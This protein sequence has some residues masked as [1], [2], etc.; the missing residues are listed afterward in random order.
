[1]EAEVDSQPSEILTRRVARRRFLQGTA[2]IGAGALLAGKLGFDMSAQVAEAAVPSTN[3]P[4]YLVSTASGVQFKPILTV[5]DLP[6][7]NGYRMVGIPDGLGAYRRGNKITLVMNHELGDTAGVVRAHGSRGAFV[8]R[9]EIKRQNL[10]VLSGQDLTQSPNDVYT[11][12]A[13]GYVAGTTAWNRFCSADMPVPPALRFGFKGTRERILLNGEESG[14]EGRAW[15]NIVTGSHAGQSWQLPRLG[16]MAFENVV[17][18]PGA[19]ERTV[20]AC[21]DDGT[22]GQV[23]IYAG[24]KQR[25]GNEIERAGLTNGK[26]YAVKINVNGAVVTAENTNDG[27]GS[28]GTYVGEGSFELAQM[29]TNGDVSSLTGAQ[30]EA[31]SGAKLAMTFLR[32]EDGAWDPSNR[33]DFYF[34]TTNA[35]SQ[36]TRLWRLRFKDVHN[37]AAGG[38]IK[39]I[40]NGEHSGY[41]PQMLDN[42]CIDRRGRIILQEDPGNQPHLAKVWLYS[43]DTD[44][45]YQIGQHNPTLFDDPTVAGF[46]TRDEESSGVIDAKYLLGEGWFLLDVQ[47]HQAIPA[48]PDTYGLVQNGQLLAMYVDP[49]IGRAGRHFHDDDYDEDKDDD[50]DE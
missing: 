2:A 26:L 15:A 38:K 32:P 18:S 3:A 45:L 28:G 21:M 9:W 14:T 31:D 16:R 41:T 48:P 35:F 30:L 4:A 42:I 13:S 23:Y 40:I 39:I 44:R 8:S 43:I 6:A 11:W 5:G 33:N 24:E 49:R 47:A 17:A 34:V 20:V 25:N 29:G 50:E 19:R 27:L 10:E 7:N 1:M 22:G 46:I 36:K 37:P 12:N